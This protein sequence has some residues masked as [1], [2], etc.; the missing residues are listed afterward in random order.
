[1][2]S[3]EIPV[4]LLEVG[5]LLAHQLPLWAA[6]RIA[7]SFPTNATIDVSWLHQQQRLPGIPDFAVEASIQLFRY[8]II[9]FHHLFIGIVQWH[10]STT[11]LSRSPSCLS[12]PTIKKI[13]EVEQ[14]RA[15]VIVL[16]RRSCVI[17]RI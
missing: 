9:Y 15:D 6:P 13:L 8:Q 17:P 12:L 2:N 4:I 16:L 7:T 5:G 10:E 1:M 11:A 14:C 3:N